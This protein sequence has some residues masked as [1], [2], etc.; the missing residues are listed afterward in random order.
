[1]ELHADFLSGYFLGTRKREDSTISVWAA[2]KTFYEIGDYQYNNRNHHGTPDERV[3]AAETGF[4]YGSRATSYAETF[5][6]GADFVLQN[7]S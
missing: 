1:M 2:G 6:A 3:L 4:K 5:R 7:F